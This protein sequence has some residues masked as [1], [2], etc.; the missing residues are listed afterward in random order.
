MV[1]PVVVC[2]GCMI[3]APHRQR[4]VPNGRPTAGLPG[5]SGPG[6]ASG[7]FRS[8]RRGY[9]KPAAAWGKSSRP[10]ARYRCLGEKQ[11]AGDGDGLL[12]GDANDLLWDR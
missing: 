8:G 6:R 4:P 9:P 3:G 12:Q 10:A 5:S 1:L 7:R 11:R 2:V